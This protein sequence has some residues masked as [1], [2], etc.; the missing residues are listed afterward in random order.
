MD[1]S[2]AKFGPSLDELLKN[3]K[4]G[5]LVSQDLSLSKGPKM[6]GILKK[7][8]MMSDSDSDDSDIFD[9]EEQEGDAPKA[10]RRQ[11]ESA[12]DSSDEDDEEDT[13][14]NLQGNF[15]P[16]PLYF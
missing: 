13:E 15:C 3:Y 5:K 11:V 14:T 6:L 7:R 4:E 2:E 8:Q 9:E 12:T 1:A 10:K 16:I